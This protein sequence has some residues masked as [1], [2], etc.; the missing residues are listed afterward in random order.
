M[1]LILLLVFVLVAPLVV[2]DSHLN[3]VQL[4]VVVVLMRFPVCVTVV[5]LQAVVVH[6]VAVLV[7]SLLN[8]AQ[9]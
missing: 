1:E 5:L 3:I 8:L 4:M 9:I 7:L 6:Q 2:A